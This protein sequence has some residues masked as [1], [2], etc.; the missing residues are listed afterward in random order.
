M[1]TTIDLDDDLM[2][3]VRTLAEERRTTMRQI[4]EEALRRHLTQPETNTYR[5]KLPV[6]QGRR[7]PLIDIDSNATLDEYLDR[8]ESNPV[9][10]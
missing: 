2:D 6:T 4:I 3:A 1:K 10:S 8:A 7:P 5:L 9:S